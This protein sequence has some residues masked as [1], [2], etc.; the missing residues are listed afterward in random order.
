LRTN[1]TLCRIAQEEI[2]MDL[3]FGSDMPEDEDPEGATQR[4]EQGEQGEENDATNNNDDDDS[5]NDSDDGLEEGSFAATR[6]MRSS[7]SPEPADE[8]DAAG[9]SSES[10]EK[11]HVQDGALDCPY[12][13][14]TP[15]I[16]APQATHINCVVTTK[17]LRWFFTGGQD[18]Y[19]R[20]HDFHQSITGKIP[21]TVAQKHPFVDTVQKSGV[22]LSYWENEEADDEETNPPGGTNSIE[23]SLSPVFCLAVQRDAMWILAGQYSGGINLQSVRV[24]EGKTVTT[25]KG[26]TAAVSSLRLARDERSLLSG[27]WDKQIY[28]WDLETGKTRRNFVAGNR[29]TGQVS[30]IALR[31]ENAPMIDKSLALPP[32][33]TPTDKGAPTIEL[34]KAT[35]PASSMS[36]DPLFDEDEDEKP[37]LPDLNTT[38]PEAHDQ[39]NGDAST[40][41]GPE[42]V[43]LSSC[44]DG[45]MSIWDRRQ[46]EAVARIPLPPGVPPWCMSACWSLDGESFYCGRRNQ[47]VEEY[48]MRANMTQPV[49]T[50][51]M[52]YNSGP[53][54]S[55]TAMPNGRSLI[56]ASADN[57]R[58]YDLKNTQ[59]GMP[60]MIIP[61]HHGGVI[62]DFW[63]DESCRYA[64]STSGNR[65]WDGIST[66]VILGYE[67]K[68][69]G[70]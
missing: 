12:Y 19:I 35:S 52:P 53:V 7:R 41:D 25:L 64:F 46:S 28:D 51:K 32:S 27:G 69:A 65:G 63:V 20:K 70:R 10:S 1:F 55:V 37:Q 50:I 62:S 39:S 43:F 38:D 68:P 30:T 2:I 59:S 34:P 8:D 42:D 36:F 56:C 29:I 61:G 21:L 11:V 18:G 23:K 31:P 17:N 16:A 13:D 22:L 15:T 33:D 49:R 6:S 9:A 45:T 44:I 48:S 47:T 26:H 57:V 3:D 4:S 40:S 60:F 67:I 5:M 14:M 58:M 54:S 24:E 66:E